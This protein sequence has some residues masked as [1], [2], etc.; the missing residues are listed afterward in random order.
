MNLL[1]NSQKTGA[2]KGIWLTLAISS[3]VVGIFCL[4]AKVVY[5]SNFFITISGLLLVVMFVSIIMLIRAYYQRA[6][7]KFT[8]IENLTTALIICPIIGGLVG[9]AL[10]LTCN[11]LLINSPFKNVP[12]E[13][14]ILC[15]ILFL[16]TISAGILAK[17]MIFR[18]KKATS[19]P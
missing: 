2:K 4:V 1:T 18:V 15:A 5:E 19:K 7:N 12:V 16:S 6:T 17:I 10:I 14:Q 11:H 8:A 9:L 13:N 3:F